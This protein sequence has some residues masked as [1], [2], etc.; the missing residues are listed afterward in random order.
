MCVFLNW[1]LNSFV[2]FPHL[3]VKRVLHLL[4]IN[5]ILN[6]VICHVYAFTV[7]WI[8]SWEHV[9]LMI[10]IVSSC[11]V[12]CVHCLKIPKSAFLPNSFYLSFPSQ[13]QVSEYKTF[14]LLFETLLVYI[15]CLQGLF[16]QYSSLLST[17]FKDD[18]KNKLVESDLSYSFFLL[19]LLSHQSFSFLFT[20][21]T[22]T[23]LLTVAKSKMNKF[24]F[25]KY[26]SSL[27]ASTIL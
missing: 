7:W 15:S 12:S 11:N 9:A 2:Q 4:H 3:R 23:A 6:I 14:I 8:S 1:I 21:M 20:T 24:I 19:V 5:L 26:F 25:V 27:C 18:S 16:S 10:E 17:L 22:H 13:I